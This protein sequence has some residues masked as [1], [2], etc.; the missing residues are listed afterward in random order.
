MFGGALVIGGGAS[1][2]AKGPRAATAATPTVTM[3]STAAP[4]PVSTAV[5]APVTAQL[6][7]TAT[8]PTARIWL[9]DQPLAGNPIAVELPVG[10]VEHTLRIEA[11]G[12]VSRTERLKLGRDRTMDVILQQDPESASGERQQPGG[13]SAS[14]RG[15]KLPPHALDS[16]NPYPK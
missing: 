11:P 6:H 8:P 13:R 10:D 2:L 4:A 15:R 5:P 16:T 1:L 9:D 12:Y 7:L 14:S 3:V